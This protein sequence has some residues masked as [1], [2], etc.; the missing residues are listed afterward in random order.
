MHKILIAPH[1]MKA[2]QAC[3]VSVFSDLSDFLLEQGFLPH[4]AFFHTG[5]GNLQDATKLAKTYLLKNE[6]KGLILHGGTSVSPVLYQKSD[7]ELNLSAHLFRDYFEIA[8][9]KL[10]L[11]NNIPILGICRGLQILNVYFGGSLK[12]INS[13]LQHIKNQTSDTTSNDVNKM[14]LKYKHKIQVKPNTWLAKLLFKSEIEVNSIHRQGIDRLSPELKSM[15]TAQDETVEIA[16]NL[17]K[18]ILGIQ[19]HP[20]LALEDENNFKILTG[21]LKLINT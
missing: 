2:Q 4:T 10:A 3:R 5:Y 16:I 1:F 8:L 11:A 12:I 15:A 14:D 19:W 7:N 9:I 21:W 20:E 6:I 13:D 18:K 17:E